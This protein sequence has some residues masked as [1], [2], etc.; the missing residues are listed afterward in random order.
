M[1]DH[2]VQRYN[3]IVAGCGWVDTSEKAR[4]GSSGRDRIDLI[5]RMSTNDL[6]GMA[7]N[8]GRATVLTN[9]LARMVDRIVVINLKDRALIL[10]SWGAATRIRKW[11]S[12]YIFFNDEIKLEDASPQWGQFDLVGPRSAAIA[13]SLI[14]GASGLKK[15]SVIQNDEAIIGR[16]DAIKGDSF[17]VVAASEPLAQ[18]RQQAAALGAVECDRELYNLLRIESGIA[19]IDHEISE[20][21]I[22]LEANLWGDVSFSKGCYIGQEII[23]RMESRGKLAKML[24]GVE[25]ASPL[26]AGTKIEGGVITSVAESPRGGWIGLAY[27]KPSQVQAGMEIHH[28]DAVIRVASLPFAS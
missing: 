19:E 16:G 2:L 14:G 18:L 5:H 15:F 12:G 13:D 23:A 6:R 3:S 22:P 26:Q 4:I 7:I 8:E 21:Y 1:N 10:G 9:A 28:D 11:L 24:A 17:F 20:E 25:S 27:L